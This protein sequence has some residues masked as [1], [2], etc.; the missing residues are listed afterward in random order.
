M[1]WHCIFFAIALAELDERCKMG[2]ARVTDSATPTTI[3]T[4][5]AA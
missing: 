1:K 2:V 5:D 3:L 4:E